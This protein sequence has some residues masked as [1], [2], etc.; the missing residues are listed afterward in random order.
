MAGTYDVKDLE[1][2]LDGEKPTYGEVT[3]EK[4]KVEVEIINLDDNTIFS[5][6]NFVAGKSSRAAG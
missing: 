4:G 6:E 1:I 2:D 3:I 5:S